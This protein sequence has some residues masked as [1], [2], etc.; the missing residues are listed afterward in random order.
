MFALKNLSSLG[1]EKMDPWDFSPPEAPPKAIVKDKKERDRWIN[2]PDTRWNVYTPWEGLNGA[3]RISKP[4][5]ESEGN[6]P[7]RLHGFAVDF[8]AVMTEDEVLKGIERLGY[9]ANYYERSLSGK[10]HL[11]WQFKNPL[12]L[13][14]WELAIEFLKVASAGLQLRAALPSFDEGH[15]LNP[16]RLLTNAGGQWLKIEDD[17]IPEAIL[18]GWLIEASGNIK[19]SAAGYNVPLDKVAEKLKTDSRFANSE[20]ASIE[21]K[22]GAQGPTWWVPASKSPKSALVK[23]SG[24][25]TFSQ[26]AERNFYTWGD[27]LG[28]EWVQQYRTQHIGESVEGI[29]FDGREYWRE[30]SRGAWKPWTK[31]DLILHLTAVRKLSIVKQKGDDSSEVAQAL[32]HIQDHG[33]VEGAAPFVFR[34]SGFLEVEGAPFLNTHT[35][36]VVQ[37]VDELSPWGPTGKFPLISQFFGDPGCVS[38]DESRPRFFRGGVKALDTFLS[39]LSHY[40][41]GAYELKLSSG[42]HV[43]ISGPVNRG[44]T[45]LNRGIVGAMMNGFR[46]AEAYLMGEDSFGSEL[47]RV[48]HWVVD[49]NAVGISPARRRRWTEAIKK[50]A[51]NG[52]FV[53]HEKFRTKQQVRWPGRVIATLNG[54]EGSTQLIPDLERSI[55]DKIHLYAVDGERATIDFLQQDAM[56]EILKK[57]IPFFCRYLLEWVTPEYCIERRRDGT[58]DYRFGAVKPWHDEQLVQAANQSSSTSGFYEVLASW[59]A[60]YFKI[61]NENRKPS[62]RVTKWCGTAF[63][64]RKKMCANDPATLDSLRGI[65]INSISSL[66][67]QLR[68]KGHHIEAEDRNGLRYWTIH[69]KTIG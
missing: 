49:D 21:F 59:S 45:F 18:V 4:T 17:M 52:T 67:M 10:C 27:L 5:G 12:V 7:Y 19:W 50:M 69:D 56:T 38:M 54:D 14:G 42:C 35:A 2:S 53:Y 43:F 11:V 65:D 60:E 39:W 22:L 47:F 29:Y 68:V 44:K 57:E 25:F 9:P 23:E 24:M 20:W 33:N 63:E 3:Q 51:A 15:F 64:L 26:N 55:L 66:L 34:P 6:T 30:I 16:T 37:P 46:E 31:D 62:E 13:A 8:D 36:R 48:A 40:Y 61:E 32:V 58:I 1:V 28:H 41:R